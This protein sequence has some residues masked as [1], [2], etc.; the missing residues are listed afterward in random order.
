[1]KNE[2]VNLVQ[3][4]NFATTKQRVEVRIRGLQ[5]RNFG[6]G[7]GAV[8][9]TI[10]GANPEDENS[11]ENPDNVSLSVIPP[12]TEFSLILLSPFRDN[13]F[14]STKYSMHSQVLYCAH[15]KKLLTL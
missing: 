11:F 15:S 7:N 8:V 13:E 1:M 6:L 4:V 14:L 5:E 3:I 10:T 9:Y 12:H 2:V